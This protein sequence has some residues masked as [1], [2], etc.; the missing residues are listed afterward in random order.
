VRTL[1]RAAAMKQGRAPALPGS[2]SPSPSARWWPPRDTGRPSQPGISRTTC[3]VP[4]S[5]RC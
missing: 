4:P 3:C 1:L 2:A 5:W